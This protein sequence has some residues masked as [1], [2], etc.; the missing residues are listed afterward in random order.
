MAYVLD[1]MVKPFVEFILGIR[2]VET[3]KALATVVSSII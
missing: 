1:E 3:D 2:T